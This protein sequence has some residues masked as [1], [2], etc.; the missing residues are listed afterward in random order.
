VSRDERAG[1][2]AKVTGSPEPTSQGDGQGAAEPLSATM[3][4]G[5]A[6]TDGSSRPTPASRGVDASSLAAGPV[7]RVRAVWRGG[8]RFDTGRPGG[9]VARLD[10]TNETG[11]S[12]VDALLSALVTCSAVDVVEILAKRRTPVE[13][14]EIE[15]TAARR[16]TTPRRVLAFDI[17]YEIDGRGIDRIQA[18]RAVRLAIGKYCTVA[19]TLKPDVVIET[20]LN[21]NGEPGEAEK[22]GVPE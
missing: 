6:E 21:L 4:S 20:T 3:P 15:V 5:V 1:A 14:F 7:N 16:A 11:Q 2:G 8:Q 19:A 9:P 13:R 10:G 12:P 22:H 17:H 18:E